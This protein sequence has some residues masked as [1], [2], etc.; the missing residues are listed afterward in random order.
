MHAC[1]CMCILRKSGVCAWLFMVSSVA[2][3]P[4]S[5]KDGGFIYKG[6]GQTGGQCGNVMWGSRQGSA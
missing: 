1:I 2:W 3:R 5:F 4:I 6:A